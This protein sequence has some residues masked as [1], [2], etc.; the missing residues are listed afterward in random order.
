[1]TRP[2]DWGPPN[3]FGLHNVHGNVSEYCRDSFDPKF[4]SRPEASVRD[5]LCNVES[6]SVTLRGGDS[7]YREWPP[8]DQPLFLRSAS[9]VG[10][11]RD[12]HGSV[13][14]RPVFELY[15]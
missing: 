9:R 11:L 14:L 12:S 5:P 6:E 2:V 1:M 4:Y 7:S 15:R 8:N 3:G 13:G 10:Y